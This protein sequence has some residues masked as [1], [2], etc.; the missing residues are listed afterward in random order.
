MAEDEQA[1]RHN[2][3]RRALDANVDELQR[4]R[5]EARLGQVFALVIGLA[6]ITGGVLAAVEGAQWSGSIIGGGGVIGLVTA[7]IIGRRRPEAPNK[8]GK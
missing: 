4:D 5:A 3:E 1:H 2:L 6:A 7:F 8:P